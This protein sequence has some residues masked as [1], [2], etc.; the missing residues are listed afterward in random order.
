MSD[1][2]KERACVLRL[3]A[4]LVRPVVYMETPAPP[5]PDVRVRYADHSVEVFEVTEVHPDERSRRGGSPARAQE[6]RRAKGNPHAIVPSWV[7]VEALPAIRRRVEEKCKK[8]VGYTVQPHETLSLL[9]MGSLPL[10]GAL[11]STYVFAPFVTVDRLNAELHEC[12]AASRFQRAY[13]YLP[14][15]GN[16]AWG[17][18]PKTGWTVLLAPQDI[19]QE[20]REVLEAL[21]PLGSGVVPP[22]TQIF[23]WPR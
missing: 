7:P 21:K 11:A 14:F 16:A 13:L 18:A 22:G 4:S 15:S 2:R 3:L 10:I 5:A 8:A 6:E 23:G 20:G 12:L 9:L 1:S 17:W 19:A